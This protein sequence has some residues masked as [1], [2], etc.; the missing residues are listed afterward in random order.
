[1]KTKKKSD[2]I[3]LNDWP[4]DHA[5]KA[6]ENEYYVEAIQVIHNFL[7]AALQD[8]FMV[9]RHGNIRGRLK[10]KWDAALEMSFINVS[11]AL[12]VTGKID[13]KTF[14]RLSQFNSLRNKL[15]HRL[16][17]EYY[18]KQYRGIPRKEYDRVYRM[19]LKLCGY[20]EG[21]RAILSTR[22]KPRGSSQHGA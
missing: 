4:P 13:K 20:V 5:R 18:E 22:G 6:Y 15:I 9:S 12:L 21:K 3:K 8:F 1:M 11:R 16:F 14:D 2:Y 10:Y 19:G 17:F 7:E